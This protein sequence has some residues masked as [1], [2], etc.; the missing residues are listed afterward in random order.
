MASLETEI[1]LKSESL[2]IEALSELRDRERATGAA[3]R[4]LIAPIRTLPV[5]LLAEIFVLTIREA[6]H[7]HDTFRVAHPLLASGNSIEL[8]S[9]IP[10]PWAQLTD[11]ALTTGHSAEI[12]LAVFAQCTKLVRAFLFTSR[13]SIIPSATGADI[14]VFRYLHV[15]SIT[16]AGD[17]VDAM[18]FLGRLAASALDALRL[19]FECE[20]RAPNITRLESNGYRSHL[21]AH[22]L[23]ATLFHAPAL[24]HL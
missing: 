9:R 13:W 5:E 16:F 18:P 14:L 8:D 15:L 23:R 1:A 19:N 6:L 7:I 2:K 17:E 10:M 21:P 12:F 22:A 4:F 11:L 20:S 3:L 24:T